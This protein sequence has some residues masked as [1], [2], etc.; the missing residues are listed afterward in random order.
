MLLTP[1]PNRW[2]YE[3][4]LLY[5]WCVA[6]KR[7]YLVKWV[8]A[9][10]KTD[11][12][13]SLLYKMAARSDEN[14]FLY[15]FSW[16]LVTSQLSYFWKMNRR[17][18]F[19]CLSRSGS[20]TPMF[21]WQTWNCFSPMTGSSGISSTACVLSWFACL[22]CRFACLLNTCFVNTLHACVCAHF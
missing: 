19:C 15:H 10:H 1:G 13:R 17:V 3:W 20:L 18:F 14:V 8:V 12:A 16:T 21:S 5:F 22:S 2:R 7:L 4:R 9:V 6:L 11:H